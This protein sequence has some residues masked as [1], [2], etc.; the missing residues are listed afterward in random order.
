MYSVFHTN[1]FEKADRDITNQL[2][3]AK[4]EGR[5][6]GKA[7]KASEIA[8]KMKA[9]GSSITDISEITGLSESEINSL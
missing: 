6:E 5:A 9:K 2:A 3:Y 8:R 1:S 4:L 7:E